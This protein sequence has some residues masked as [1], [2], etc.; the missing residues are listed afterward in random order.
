MAIRWN[1]A[2]EVPP[3]GRGFVFIRP[4]LTGRADREEGGGTL[5]GCFVQANPAG[6]SDLVP[7]ILWSWE[8]IREGGEEREG[9]MVVCGDGAGLLG[10]KGVEGFCLF[11]LSG[12]EGDSVGLYF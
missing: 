3:G 5:R 4:D 7:D 10:G 2:A 11:G 1:G 6:L 9:G 12:S 8:R